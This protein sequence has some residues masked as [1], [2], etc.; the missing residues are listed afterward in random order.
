MK[1]Y[2]FLILSISSFLDLRAQSL[3]VKVVDT[4][5]ETLP[6]AGVYINNNQSSVT[7]SG[8]IAY[9]SFNML[10]DGDTITSTYIGMKASSIIYNK[11]LQGLSKCTIVLDNNLVYE[12]DPVVVKAIANDDW[13]FFHKNLNAPKSLFFK[14]F[15]MKGKFKAEVS[16]SKDSISH[17][18]EGSFEFNNIIPPK[19]PMS[20]YHKYYFAKMPEITSTEEDTIIKNRIIYAIDQSINLSIQVISRIH[21]EYSYNSKNSKVSYLGLHDNCHFFRIVYS[22]NQILL[23]INK[24]TKEIETAEFYPALKKYSGSLESRLMTSTIYKKQVF[25]KRKKEDIR[26]VPRKIEYND[27][28]INISLSWDKFKDNSKINLIL[29]DVITEIVN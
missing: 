6:Y 16:F 13:K 10:N 22:S 21:L 17:N 14:S 25:K 2:I 9:I 8:G 5:G 24:D 15:I 11:K 18:I 7:D 3:Q 4:K 20:D 12:L 28:F 27:K 23:S 19:T 1:H 29:T 26:T